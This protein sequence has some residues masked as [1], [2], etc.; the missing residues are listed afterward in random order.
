MTD[1]KTPPEFTTA[2][3]CT[4]TNSPTRRVERKEQNNSEPG[5]QRLSGSLGWEEGNLLS[6][7]PHGHKAQ[8][9]RGARRRREGGILV[10]SR[11][12]S[13]VQGVVRWSRA[14]RAEAASRCATPRHARHAMMNWWNATGEDGAAK[15]AK[16]SHRL[17]REAPAPKHQPD[18]AVIDRGP[19]TDDKERKR[20]TRRIYGGT[21]E[22]RVRARG[23]QYRVRSERERGERR[24]EEPKR[25][26]ANSHARPLVRMIIPPP[27]SRVELVSR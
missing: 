17:G 27:E 8:A 11:Q 22:A 12:R 15:L 13:Q 10:F 1:S 3:R 24:L 4:K 20:K 14:I 16:L 9:R 23:K 2:G 19:K 5:R 6:G 26:S 21:T 7:G 18:V 25:K